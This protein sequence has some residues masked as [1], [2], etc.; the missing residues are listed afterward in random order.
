MFSFEYKRTFQVKM[1]KENKGEHEQRT[2]E[3]PGTYEM[4]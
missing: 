3:K 2:E 1:K 4:F